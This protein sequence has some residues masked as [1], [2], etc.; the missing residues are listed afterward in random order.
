MTKTQTLT[1]KFNIFIAWNI[2][3]CDTYLNANI[4]TIVR[5][6]ESHSTLSL[7]QFKVGRFQE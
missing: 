1:E 3:Q 6:I 2:L 7:K 5:G 4:R